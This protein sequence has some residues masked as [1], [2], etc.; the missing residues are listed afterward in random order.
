MVEMI[1]LA[2][3]LASCVT[4]GS[5]TH[6]SGYS[7]LLKLAAL[8]VPPTA[9]FCAS[10]VIAIGSLDAAH[11]IGLGV[12]TQISIMGVD[13]IPMASWSTINLTKIRQPLLPLLMGSKYPKKL[14]WRL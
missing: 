3:S 2:S 1:S 13:D 5:Y 12:Q 14:L 9:L 10:D 6:D 11:K 7:N 4:W 8:D